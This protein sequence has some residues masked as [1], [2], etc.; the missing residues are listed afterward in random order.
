MCVLRNAQMTLHGMLKHDAQRIHF[1]FPAE[2]IWV[3]DLDRG[4]KAWYPEPAVLLA[5][6]LKRRKSDAQQY[7]DIVAPFLDHVIM[8]FPIVGYPRNPPHPH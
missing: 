4:D 8:D 3:E 6:L 5:T 7:E 2:A 1:I